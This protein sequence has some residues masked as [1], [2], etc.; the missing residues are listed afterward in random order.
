VECLHNTSNTFGHS[1]ER[2]DQNVGAVPREHGRRI[3]VCPSRTQQCVQEQMCVIGPEA[4]KDEADQCDDL[5]YGH[6]Q[7][8]H[9]ISKNLF[10]KTVQVTERAALTSDTANFENSDRDVSSIGW[11]RTRTARDPDERD[12]IPRISQEKITDV[13]YG[14]VDPLV[15]V[16]TLQRQDQTI[17]FREDVLQERLLCE[18]VGEREGRRVQCAVAADVRREIERGRHNRHWP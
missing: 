3:C 2:Q 1:V 12:K 9:Q 16:G 18:R 13:G 8:F 4:R 10:F 15:K 5:A 6:Q 14:A 7:L 11:N 17:T